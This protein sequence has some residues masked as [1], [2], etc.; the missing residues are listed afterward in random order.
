MD[1]FT[2]ETSSLLIGILAKSVLNLSWKLELIL[3]T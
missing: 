3:K 2:P 1:A